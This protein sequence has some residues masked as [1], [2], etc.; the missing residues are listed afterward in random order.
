MN[1]PLYKFLRF[2]SLLVALCGVCSLLLFVMFGEMIFLS[3]IG[4]VLLGGYGYWKI[5]QGIRTN[6]Q[7][8][9]TQGVWMGII[10]PIVS[11][12]VLSFLSSY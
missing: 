5:G 9:V 8:F 2:V 6:T 4:A 10:I 1:K 12:I 11:Y 3:G 7:A